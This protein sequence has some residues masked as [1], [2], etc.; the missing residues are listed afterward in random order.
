MQSLYN[1]YDYFE[2]FYLLISNNVQ[3]HSILQLIPKE[4]LN[5]EYSTIVLKN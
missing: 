3:I 5:Q 2:D 1:F 4:S